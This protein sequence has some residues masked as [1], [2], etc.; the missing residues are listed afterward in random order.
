MDKTSIETPE[1]QPDSSPK[2]PIPGN[3]PFKPGQSGNPKGRPKLHNTFSD[4]ARSLMEAQEVNVTWEV[5]GKKKSVKLKMGEK[6]NIYF[7]L[8]SALILEGLRGDT[9]AIKELID[10]TEGKAIQKIVGTMD[11]NISVAEQIMKIW[12]DDPERAPENAVE[13]KKVENG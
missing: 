2:N 12:E 8:V 5:G 6:Q 3:T 11:V 7:G 1:K 4:T 10:R 13:F 9:K